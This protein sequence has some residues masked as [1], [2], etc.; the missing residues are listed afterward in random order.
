MGN[1]MNIL[2]MS[3]TSTRVACDYHNGSEQHQPQGDTQPEIATT[4]PMSPMA[5][6]EF[7]TQQHAY[8]HPDNNLNKWMEYVN[9]W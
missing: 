6:Q 1:S 9:A 2:L 8:L 7:P 4:H 3:Q 5:A